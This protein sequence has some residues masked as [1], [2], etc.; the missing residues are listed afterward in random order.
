[1]TFAAVGSIIQA[2]S[3]SFSLTP[4]TVGDLIL[5][6]VSGSSSAVYPVS[7]S[8]SNVTWSSWGYYRGT[9][10]GYSAAVFAGKV[11]AASA[12]TVTVAWS[13]TAPSLIFVDGQEFSST[14]GSWALDQIGHIDTTGAN[15]TWAALTPA[16]A[17][18][19]Y[20]GYADDPG[21]AVAGSTSGY[22]YVVDA[23]SDAMAY[24]PACTSAAQAPVWGDTGQAFGMMVLVK[25]TGTTLTGQASAQVAA[26]VAAAATVTP[27]AGETA[28]ATITAVVAAAATAIP[29]ARSYGLSAGLAGSWLGMLGGTAYA[30]PS[31]TWVQLHTGAPGPAGTAN[32]SSVTTRQQVTWGGPAGGLI[33]AASSPAWPS[34]AGVSGE[35]IT[36]ITV[37]TAASGGTFLF[38]VPLAG[39]PAEFTC[40]A[41]TPGVF[42]AEGLVLAAGAA[43]V[44]APA[45]GLSLPGG[46]TGDVTYYV[47]AVAGAT[48]ELASTLGGPSLAATSAG[49]GLVRARGVVAAATG[50]TLTLTSLSAGFTPVAS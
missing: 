37:W 14:V 7:L 18:E 27:P 16:G 47:A 25:E 29:A 20:F 31:A 5:I 28:A 48:F 13:G 22:T 8:S 43:V 34:W 32:V 15:S 45:A 42:T 1:M 19:L 41:G 23:Q 2:T 44:L 50:G 21:T 24:N 36:D 10:N 17:G 4:H 26:Q 11:T 38:S 3:S 6:E 40:P 33:A 30:A 49:G 39:P 46:F 9:A 12:A 35:V